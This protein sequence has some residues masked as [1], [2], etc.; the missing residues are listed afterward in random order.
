[1]CGLYIGRRADLLWKPE[2]DSRSK[3]KIVLHVRS[4]VWELGA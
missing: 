1:M 2:D 3:A 4:S